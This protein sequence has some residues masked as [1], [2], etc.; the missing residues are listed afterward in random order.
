MHWRK[1]SYMKWVILLLPT[2]L[3]HRRD[4]IASLAT[5]LQGRRFSVVVDLSGGWVAEGIKPL[6]QTTP[7]ITDLKISRLRNMKSENLSTTGNIVSIT[8][9][10]ALQLKQRHDFSKPLFLDD[11]SFSG[12][13]SIAAM[14]LL[15]LRPETSTHGFLILNTGELGPN[16]GAL[17]ALGDI[18]TDCVGGMLMHTPEDDGWHIEDL[19]NQLHI[20]LNVELSLLLQRLCIESGMKSELV[21]NVI[22]REHIRTALFPNTIDRQALL[23]MQQEGRFIPHKNGN[24]EHGI[25][26]RN[27]QLLSSPFFAEHINTQH[28]WKDPERIIH[29]LSQI[30]EL[31]GPTRIKPSAVEGLQLAVSEA[32]S[33]HGKESVHRFGRKEM[34]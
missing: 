7:V 29:I 11:V 31:V 3:Q 24:I 21:E 12:F 25:H 16:P 1:N 23:Q 28:L 22:S 5:Q 33:P 30:Q 19:W 27:P 34:A 14:Q 9:N 8:K 17:K 4:F 26:A 15:D 2:A 18:G 6:L 20:H 32:L 10:D 13:T